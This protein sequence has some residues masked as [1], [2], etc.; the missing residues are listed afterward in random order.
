MIVDGVHVMETIDGGSG[1]TV[2]AVLSE[3]APAMLVTVKEIVPVGVPLN[4]G[5]NVGVLLVVGVGLAP[6]AT[7]A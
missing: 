4:V 5:E 3:S 2:T 7:Q 1:L 6:D